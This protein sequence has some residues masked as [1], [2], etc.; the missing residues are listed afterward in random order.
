MAGLASIPF[1]DDLSFSAA[2]FADLLHSLDH[3]RTDLSRDELNALPTTSRTRL[4]RAFAST[5]AKEQQHAH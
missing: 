2:F 4:F 5:I 3:S 1:V